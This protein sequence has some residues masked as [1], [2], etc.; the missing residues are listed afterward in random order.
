MSLG[1]QRSNLDLKGM[2]GA[3]YS[4][5]LSF[6]KREIYPVREQFSM[7]APGLTYL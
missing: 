4:R 6:R 2:S 5:G 1:F 3:N 7:I